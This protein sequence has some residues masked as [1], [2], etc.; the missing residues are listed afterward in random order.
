MP[1]AIKVTDD[2]SKNVLE[3]TNKYEANLGDLEITKNVPEFNAAS[4]KQTFVF[5]ITAELDGETVYD[6]IES[7]DFENAGEKTVKLAE[8]IPVGAK[9]TV[10][11]VYSGAA[12]ELT[13][14]GSQTAEILPPDEG[15][16][17]V[18]FENRPSGEI[19]EGYGVL[20]EYDYTG[21]EGW[22]HNVD[23]TDSAE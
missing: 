12:Y 13:V 22:V 10:T 2:A 23:K 9:V 19:T 16:A 7:I 11:E 20:N 21:E 8:K 15:T 4:G 6:G 14:K 5:S 18:S 17:S 1:D 3:I